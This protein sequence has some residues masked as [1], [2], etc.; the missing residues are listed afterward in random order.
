MIKSKKFDI[1]DFWV[2]I[3]QVI[4]GLS[5]LQVWIFDNLPIHP[6]LSILLIMIICNIAKYGMRLN[7][8]WCKGGFPLKLYFVIG[9]IDILQVLITFPEAAILCF[10]RLLNIFLFL[11]YL[12]NTYA[13]LKRNESSQ[14]ETN[15]AQPYLLYSVYNTIVVVVVA[16]LIILGLVNPFS[17]PV[18][19]NS[20][21]ADNIQ[22]ADYT[23]YYFPAYLSILTP[24]ARILSDYGLPMLTGLSHEPHVLNFAILPAFFL[25]LAVPNY[26]HFRPFIYIFFLATMM[27]SFS[28][29][30]IIV[31]CLILGLDIIWQIIVFRKYNNLKFFAP[32]LIIIIV[33]CC[34]FSD[35]VLDVILAKT[36]GNNTSSMEYSANMLSYV[37]CP[38]TLLGYG[39]LPPL[40]FKLTDIS[41]GL[42][43][44]LLDIVF[45]ASIVI[46]CFKGVFKKNETLHYISLACLYF[47]IHGLKLSFLIFSYPLLIF[48]LFLQCSSYKTYR[49]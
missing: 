30:A 43:T 37:L 33:C 44:A 2:I 7:L 6:S 29:T 20:L 38:S 10:I 35:I 16:V 22:N 49:T 19:N 24:N 28:A 41:I 1:V 39:N 4:S 14:I 25:L 8:N 42:I 26:K 46:K 13:K 34:Y 18:E 5:M 40:G 15:V 12:S 36:K 21:M 45:F 9:M 17:N 27:L 32:I 47:V 48:L 3:L 11:S 31:F 23:L